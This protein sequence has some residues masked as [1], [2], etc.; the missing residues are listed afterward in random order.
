MFYRLQV[1]V[2]IS[3]SVRFYKVEPEKINHATCKHGQPA[4]ASRHVFILFYTFAYPVKYQ[5]QSRKTLGGDILR[6]TS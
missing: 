4:T 5:T 2:D 1:V 6:V 3:N